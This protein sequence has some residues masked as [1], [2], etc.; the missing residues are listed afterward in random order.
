[1]EEQLRTPTLGIR[2]SS[3]PLAQQLA[4][5]AGFPISTTSANLHGQPNPYSVQEIEAQFKDADMK[6]DLIL[7]SGTLPPNQPST[8]IDC[9]KETT[10]QKRTGGLRINN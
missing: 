8:V 1:M 3:H 7:D 10:E 2:I 4:A 6:P 5:S 9:T